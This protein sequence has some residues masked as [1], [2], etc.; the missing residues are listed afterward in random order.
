MMEYEKLGDM[1]VLKNNLGVIC[2]VVG[3]M[4]RF[5]Q[6]VTKEEI[7]EIISIVEKESSK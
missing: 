2:K 6:I 5:H 1:I 7:D 3:S 4:Y